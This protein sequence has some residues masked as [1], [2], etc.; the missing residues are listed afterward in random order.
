MN[1]KV[2]PLCVTVGAL[3]CLGRGMFVRVREAHHWKAFRGGW[4]PE[5][6]CTHGQK[7][8]KVLLGHCLQ[9]SKLSPS[10]LLRFHPFVTRY[11]SALCQQQPILPGSV[12]HASAV[13]QFLL[14]SQRRRWNLA[15]KRQ[16]WRLL[17]VLY[18]LIVGS[19]VPLS[20]SFTLFVSVT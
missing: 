17:T 5:T 6:S 12:Q 8:S 13:P 19:L 2:A 14:R 11:F 20:E 18:V 15:V 7:R 4:C 9:F 16:H 1:K 10:S 3:M